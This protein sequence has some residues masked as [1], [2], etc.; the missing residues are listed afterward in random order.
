[1]TIPQ[2]RREHAR[3]HPAHRPDH[4][5]RPSGFSARGGWGNIL[6]PLWQTERVAGDIKTST[7]EWPFLARALGWEQRLGDAAAARGKF[8]AGLYE[9]L[10]FGLKQAWACMFGGML[11]ALILLTSLF[12]PAHAVLPRLD[13]LFG[14]A[15]L[16][17]AGMLFCK[18]ESLAEA[19]IILLFHITGM[20]M[21][22]FKTAIGAWIYPEHSYLRFGHVPLFTGFMY[23]AIGSYLFRIWR[24]L[25][26][27]FHAH[28]PL[29]ALACLALAIYVNFFSSHFLPD[30]RLPLLAITCL[31]FARARVYF[32]PWR[33]YRSMPLLLGFL[34][35]ALFIWLAE[36]I[37]TFADLW[38]Y[39]S[40]AAH[41]HAVP[42]QK[43]LAWLLLMLVS[44]TMVAFA[45][46]PL[47]IWQMADAV[48]DLSERAGR[49]GT[50]P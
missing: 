43:L 16:I 30:I 15:L 20:A 40:Q 36:N 10:R 33:T 21:E 23:A 50:L 18:L 24:L 26:F 35:V 11:L 2:R 32:R 37:G 28:P 31:V 13:A 49:A 14:M 9:F 47:G 29:P 46:R 6:P 22:I 3:R 42:L 7:G 8:A 38:R 25:D 12:Y 34:L 48:S 41:W 5:R 44:Y 4:W 45:Q 39:P 17:Q 1:M 27:R 19:R